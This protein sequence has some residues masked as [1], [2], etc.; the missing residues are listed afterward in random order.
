MVGSALILRPAAA[1]VLRTSAQIANFGNKGVGTVMPFGGGF[2][3]G[4]VL[5]TVL[6]GL[7]I[8][9]VLDMFGLGLIG[10][11]ERPDAEEMATMIEEMVDS[12]Y[13]QIPGLRRDGTTGANN[14]LHWN[15]E[16]DSARPFL[17]SEYIGRNFV[18]A[19]RK[20]ERT[21]RYT[22]RPRP[23]GRTRRGS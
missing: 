13:I 4:S 1:I 16:D 22:S 7:G 17:T 14:W 23:R 20:N 3:G 18:N 9:T 6:T 5:R 12:G 10:G 2:S 11:G 15:I 8:E 21:P 19:V